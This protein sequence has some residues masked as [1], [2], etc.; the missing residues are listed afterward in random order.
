MSRA[1]LAAIALV[2]LAGLTG[3]GSDATTRSGD[4]AVEP[5]T[6]PAGGAIDPALLEPLTGLGPCEEPPSAP[7]D[8]GDSDLPGLA[9]PPS[10]VVTQ[11]NDAGP[12]TQV[13]G[14]V[15]RT[16]VEVRAHYQDG[17]SGLDVLTIEDEVREA[18]ILATDGA[19]RLFVKAQAVCERGS[20]FVAFL[21][22]ESAADALPAPAL[23]GN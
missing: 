17:S 2:G 6:P 13:R 3:C 15:Q 19:T 22:P 9:L 11:V 18:E 1:F 4:V 14:Y 10:A 12:L 7:D 16:P 8:V 20:V 5:S 23:G 21:A